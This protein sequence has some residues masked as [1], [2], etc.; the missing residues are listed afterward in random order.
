MSLCSDMLSSCSMGFSASANGTSSWRRVPEVVW[1][2]MLADVSR[3]KQQQQQKMALACS[4]HV[5]TSC[6]HDVINRRPAETTLVQCYCRILRLKP[7]H[8]ILTHSIC[9]APTLQPLVHTAGCLNTQK[10]VRTRSGGP[11]PYHVVRCARTACTNKTCSSATRCVGSN[12]STGARLMLPALT[13][14]H[15]SQPAAAGMRTLP[16]PELP[17]GSPPPL[18]QKPPL[19][20][21]E[22]RPQLLQQASCPS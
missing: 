20:P 3:C 18:P 13:F 16:Q 12:P 14:P 19:E 21:L 7:L 17:L 4:T 10:L 15:H 22:A 6:D 1:S 5:V 2:L 9:V 8:T 11:T